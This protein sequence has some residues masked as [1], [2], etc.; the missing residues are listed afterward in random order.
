VIVILRKWPLLFVCV[1]VGVIGCGGSGSGGG[2][3][4]TGTTGTTGSTVGTTGRSTQGINIPNPVSSVGNLFPQEPQGNVD[5]YFLPGQGRQAQTFTAVVN[6]VNFFD[7]GGF[8]T[9]LENPLE[10]GPTIGLDGFN[11]VNLPLNVHVPYPGTGESVNSRYLTE[12]DLTFNSLSIN[13]TGGATFNGPFAYTFPG[14]TNITVFPGRFTALQLYVNSGTWDFSQTP[15]AFQ[16]ATFEAAN[17]N[18]QDS[19]V[20]GFLSDYLSFDISHV[21]NRPTFTNFA[22]TAGRI[23]VSG[24]FFAEGQNTPAKS[25]TSTGY[26]VLTPYGVLPGTYKGVDPVV[27]VATYQLVQ[28]NPNN[29][30]VNPGS[31]TSLEGTWYDQSAR[32]TASDSTLMISFPG[33]GDTASQQ[34]VIFTRSGGVITNMYFGTLNYTGAGGAV[35]FNAYPIFDLEP[36]SVAG[37]VSGT[38]SALTD[39]NG[40]GLSKSG[41]WWQAVRAGTYTITSGT[42]SG[43]TSS[44]R[45]FV[46][47]V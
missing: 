26:E 5:V 13:G 46:Y 12:L 41:S 30:G 35:T 3:A 27:G 36:G 44:A 32:V 25:T 17:E 2:T 31:I 34:L 24:D 9:V 7:N 14:L 38:L 39:K 20:D 37:K 18:P 6:S 1:A 22:G 42:P 40:N 21:A 47:R 11:P 15:P 10:Q 19:K 29:L 45:L 16:T 33:K 8:S 43:I 28:P 4:T 23:F